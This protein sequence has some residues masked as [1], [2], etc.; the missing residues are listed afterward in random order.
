MVQIVVKY[1]IF[2]TITL[3]LGLGLGLEGGAACC[4]KWLFDYSCG[5][6]FGQG[7]FYQVTHWVVSHAYSG[8]WLVLKVYLD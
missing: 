2:Q 8:H 5:S 1:V 3:L 6:D 7:T 4:G